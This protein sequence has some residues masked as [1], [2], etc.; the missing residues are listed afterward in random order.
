MAVSGWWDPGGVT[1]SPPFSNISQ[2]PVASVH[3]NRERG[4]A[5]KLGAGPCGWSFEH[6]TEDVSTTSCT[7][8]FLGRSLCVGSASL[9]SIF[10]V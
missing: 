5:E 8:V 4:S 10:S 2:L 1:V 3:G 7:A 6:S 9:C